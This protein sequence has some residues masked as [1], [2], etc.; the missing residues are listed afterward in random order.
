[1]AISPCCQVW[2][3]LWC[4]DYRSPGSLL[5][6]PNGIIPQAA[7][8]L[9]FVR[10]SCASFTHKWAAAP[11]YG[12]AAPAEQHTQDLLNKWYLSGEEQ[13]AVCLGSSLGLKHILTE[14]KQNV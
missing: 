10:L 4:S 1:M 5:R 12:A 7:K 8:L 11:S 13:H 14:A 9:L 3:G 6:F 2:L